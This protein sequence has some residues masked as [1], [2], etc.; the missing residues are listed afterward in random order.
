[1]GNSLSAAR[2]SLIYA[3]MGLLWIG[4]SDSFLDM[5]VDHPETLVRLGTVKGYAYVSVTAVLLYL[6]LRLWQESLVREDDPAQDHAQP[7]SRR[8]LFLSLLSLALAV[9]LIGYGVVHMQGPALQKSAFE[10]LRAIAEMKSAQIED[11]MKERRSD[12]AVLASSQDL[13]EYADRLQRGDEGMRRLLDDRLR[14][15]TAAYGYGIGLV[16]RSGLRFH[17]DVSSV[18][19]RLLEVVWESGE[20]GIRDLYRDAD[21]SIRLDL[22]VPLLLSD[23]GDAYGAVAVV[24]MQAPVDK[25]LFPL[26]QTWP[27]PSATAEIMLLRQEDD[28]VLVL[29]ELRY[30][31]DSALS[32]RMELATPLL[33]T[34]V[35]LRNGVPGTMAATDY[36]GVAVYAATRPLQDMPWHLV[37]KIDRQEVMSGLS[38]LLFWISVVA[39]FAVVSVTS[40][41]IMLWRMQGHTHQL[42]L[43]AQAADKDRILRHFYD[44]PLIGMAIISPAENR[45]L[46]A[47]D[48]LCRMLGYSR[49]EML[50]QTWMALLHAEELPADLARIRRIL[51]G[52]SDGYQRD[53]R[54]VC[55][56]GEILDATISVQCVRDKQG[57]VELVVATIQDITERKAAEAKLDFYAHHD[58]LTGLANRLR[59]MSRLEQSLETVRRDGGMLALLMLDLDRFKDVN[60]SFGHQAGDELLQQVAALLTQRLR[61]ADAVSRLGG[62]EFAI[63]LTQIERAEDAARVAQ[64][65]TDALREPWQLSNGIEV[66]I[67]A[68]VGISLFPGHGQ[69]AELMLQQVDAA[70]YQAKAEGRGSVRYYSD[71]LTR[72]ARS[73]IDLEARLRRAVAMNQLRAH[74]QPQVDIRSGKVVG[75]EALV[76]WE[77]PLEGL[78]PPAVFIPVAE[79][80]GLIAE[81]GEWMLRETCRQGRK[82]MER[83]LPPLTLAVNLSPHQFRHGDLGS[84]VARVLA[85][86]G[87]PATRLELELTE[88]VLMSRE[89]EAVAMLQRLRDQG[90][91]L[92]IDDFGTGYSSLAY[93][94]RFPIDVLKIDKGFISDIPGDRDDCEIAVAIIAMAHA[95]GFKVLAEGVEIRDQLSFLRRQGCDLYQGYLT[96]P[97]LPAAEFEVLFLQVAAKKSG[98]AG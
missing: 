77:D 5:L 83:G 95:L 4:A 79:E 46:H 61:G 26:I 72:A 59:L 69:T 2:I 31:A 20:T 71:D 75:A 9:P 91:R 8:Y 65:I 88:S 14:V 43:L 33:A 81:I 30:A 87:F 63:L 86:T 56:G 96:S 76:R 39:F 51:A 52:E 21:G 42:E 10:D 90:V 3:F 55:R 36:R 49:A 48:H 40:A 15:F 1:M 24:I 68:S 64:E 53:T 67:G 47:N 6:L 98:Y 89:Q 70:L 28:S 34:T 25:F 35:S 13:A 92:A 11:W 97:A 57:E 38:D 94:K 29:N 12:A 82:W 17:G 45:T 80:T 18:D 93:L 54:L 78:I 58:P 50:E 74:F 60:D 23:S 84:L 16:D 85:E 73:R 41:V 27:T 62:D 66:R 32:K 7:P 44:L 37:A 19:P 22:Y